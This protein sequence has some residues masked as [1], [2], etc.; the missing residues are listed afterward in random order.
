MIIN[1]MASNVDP[2]EMAHYTIS[3]GSTVCI[4]IYTGLFVCVEVLWPSQPIGVMLSAVSLPNHT[5]T[6][7][8]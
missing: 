8:A 5:F 2:D 3:S 1:K 7:Q 6:G 4:G